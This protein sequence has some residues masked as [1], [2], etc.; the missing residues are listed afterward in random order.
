MKSELTKKYLIGI[1]LPLLLLFSMTILPLATIFFG[2]TI[3]L[4]TRPIDPRDLFRGDYV[5]LN[6]E[7]SEIETTK[8]PKNI[9]DG[10]K[11]DYYQLQNKEIFVVLKTSPTYHEVEYATLE[12]PNSKLFLKGRIQWVNI[13]YK[14][15]N[16]Q[17]PDLSSQE[18]L[19]VQVQYNLDKYFV[20]ENTGRDLEDLASKGQ[21][22]AKV[23]VFNGYAQLVELIAEE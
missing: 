9:I 12:K 22:A 23:K 19:S 14:S 16:N 20:P 8:L 13:E 10:Y 1:T 11:E 15:T 6:Y 21:L 3:L 2:E 17:N 5:I 4:K 18:L 7:I